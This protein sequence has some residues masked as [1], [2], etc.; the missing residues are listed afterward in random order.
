[1][2][3]SNLIISLAAA[4]LTLASLAATT[5]NLPAAAPVADQVAAIAVVDLAPIQ[6]HASAAELRAAALLP[7]ANPNLTETSA[8]ARAALT[9][10]APVRL[11]ESAVAMPYYSFG[12]TL[13]RTSKE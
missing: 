7:A 5:R 11:L 2:Q 1:M 6:V 4:M 3:V 9:N 10:T 12:D 8:P 13:G